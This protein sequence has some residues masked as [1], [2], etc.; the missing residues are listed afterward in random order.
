LSSP[1]SHV[2][3]C[4]LAFATGCSIPFA[5]FEARRHR[6]HDFKN[7]GLRSRPLQHRVKPRSQVCGEFLE[8]C[9]FLSVCECVCLFV[10]VCVCV[11]ICVCACVCVCVCVCRQKQIL[12]PTGIEYYSHHINPGKA[13]LISQGTVTQR[14]IFYQHTF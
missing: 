10:C 8:M 2:P 9:V 11:C 13:I 7:E 14:S 5:V 6:H 3:Q 4:L 12:I 1:P